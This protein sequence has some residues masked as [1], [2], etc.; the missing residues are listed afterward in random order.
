MIVVSDT[1]ALTTLVKA[2]MDSILPALF[3][4]VVIPN[5]VRD[6]FLSFHS[7]LPTWCRVETAV[8]S[9]LLA[10]L[11]IE[12]DPGEAEAIALAVQLQATMILLDDRKGRRTADRLRLS[13]LAL[14][15][16]M[17]AAKRQG[18]ISSVK[19]AFHKLACEGNYRIAD[20]IVFELLNSVGEG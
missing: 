7:V 6:E 20:A 9:P 10:G 3:G 12:I 19:E 11:R 17:V 4:E 2:G 8:A 13:H 1:T 15:A 16:L 18:L 5:A 14:P